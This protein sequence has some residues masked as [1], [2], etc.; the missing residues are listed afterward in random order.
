[1]RIKSIA[2]IAA[3]LLTSYAAQAQ[4][5]L[6][7]WTFDGQTVAA[8]YNSPAPFTGFGTAAVLGL[9]NTYNANSSS[10]NADVSPQAGASTG[11]GSSQWRLRGTPGNG[12]STS[13][14]IGS[15]GARFAAS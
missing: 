3:S 7:A 8:P 15:Q 1:M 13:A 14:P 5:T 2:C 10:P 11:A 12:W 6:T 9:N 4:T